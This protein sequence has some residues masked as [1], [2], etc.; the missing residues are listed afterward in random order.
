VSEPAPEA[1]LFWWCRC[2][3]HWLVLDDDDLCQHCQHE[4]RGLRGLPERVSWGIQVIVVFVEQGMRLV[5][6]RIWNML[7]GR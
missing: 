5:A 3:G 6:R 7:R 2:C 1:F 4:R